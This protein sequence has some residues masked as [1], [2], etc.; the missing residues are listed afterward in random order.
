MKIARAEGLEKKEKASPL[1]RTA[2]TACLC[3]LPALEDWA[4]AGRIG[5]AFGRESNRLFEIRVHQFSNSTFTSDTFVRKPLPF[6]PMET[7][8]Y[9]NPQSNTPLSKPAMEYGMLMGILLII[10][11]TLPYFTPLS[12]EGWGLKLITWGIMLAGII[13]MLQHY[14]DKRNSGRLSF[15]RGVGLSALTGV[16]AGILQAVFVIILFKFIDPTLIDQIMEKG[17]DEMEKQG[18]TKEQIEMGMKVM[19]WMMKLP[20][21]AV[22]AFLGSVMNFVIFGLISSAIVKK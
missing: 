8:D 7:V 14:R 5:L 17:L 1:Y 2:T 13:T 4:G 21:L 12:M 9:S 10:A 19:S 22:M 15:G 18:Q 11:S 6:Y 16:F 3:C 20:V